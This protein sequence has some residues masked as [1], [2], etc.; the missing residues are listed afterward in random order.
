MNE[1]I[2]ELAE[3]AGFHFYDMHDVDG[4]D[5][6]ETIEA[7]SWAAAEKLVELIL[8]ECVQYLNGEIDR[9]CEYQNSL[10]ELD[11]NRRDDVSIAIEKCMDNI[12]GLKE[13]FGVKE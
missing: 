8:N 7:D 2:R 5:L 9:L 13:H 10:P 11:Q 12:Q 6:G 4:Q 3:R 1:R